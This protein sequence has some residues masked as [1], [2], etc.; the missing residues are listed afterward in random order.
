[1]GGKSLCTDNADELQLTVPVEKSI[2]I[3]KSFPIVELLRLRGVPGL[4]APNLPKS[5]EIRLR[6][7]WG[8]AQEDKAMIG[9]VVSWGLEDA[10]GLWDWSVCKLVGRLPDGSIKIVM[11][12]ASMRKAG[13]THKGNRYIDLFKIA[14]ASLA[15]MEELAGQ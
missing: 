14:I 2:T 4:F 1:M 9:V 15:V 6:V 12:E 10:G 11:D 13:K 7:P 5:A 3:T 8:T